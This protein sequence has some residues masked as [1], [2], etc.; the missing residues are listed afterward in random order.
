MIRFGGGDDARDEQS[1]SIGR[2]FLDKTWTK[3]Y[4]EGIWRLRLCVVGA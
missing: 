1:D 3:S 4:A 2:A